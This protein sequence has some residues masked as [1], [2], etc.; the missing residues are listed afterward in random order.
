MEAVLGNCGGLELHVTSSDVLEDIGWD[1][2]PLGISASDSIVLHQSQVHAASLADL[3]PQ[4]SLLFLCFLK[5]LYETT[6][7]C[8]GCLLQ[9]G[10]RELRELARVTHKGL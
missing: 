6:K 4:R 2:L 1:I 9:V 8:Q 5:S 7:V 3:L 10:V